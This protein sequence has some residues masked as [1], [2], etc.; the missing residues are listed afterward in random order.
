[1]GQQ[2]ARVRH[3]GVL[4][5]SAEDDTETKRNLETFRLTLERLGWSEG[6]NLHVEYRFA[7]GSRG[8]EQ[9][10][11]HEMIGLR[12]DVVVG[13]STPVT[14]ALQRESR[15]IPIVFNVVSDPIGSGFVASL[16]RPGGNLTGFL[17][18][19]AGI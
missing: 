12:P 11:A 9:A 6:R 1:Q 3:I 8:L 19:E 13:M 5:G 14:A 2:G 4:M 16:A 15:T 17:Y 10:T 7:P 18:V